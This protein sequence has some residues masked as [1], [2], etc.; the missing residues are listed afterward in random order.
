M[1]STLGF[2]LTVL[3]FAHE[4]ELLRRWK[5]QQAMGHERDHGEWPWAA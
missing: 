1:L 5:C 3:I 4:A 2:V